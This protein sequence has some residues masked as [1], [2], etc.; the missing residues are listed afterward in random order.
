MTQKYQSHAPGPS[1]HSFA[2]QEQ[3]E[4]EGH[5]EVVE[6]QQSGYYS[7]HGLST[8]G[9]F[10]EQLLV[11]RRDD[12]QWHCGKQKGYRQGLEQHHIIK[13]PKE[14]VGIIKNES[15][16]GQQSKSQE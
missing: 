1:E 7:K 16:E 4:N 11:V 12:G 3:D 5:D 14:Q 10:R 2:S 9:K 8:F 15:E 13:Q 6:Q